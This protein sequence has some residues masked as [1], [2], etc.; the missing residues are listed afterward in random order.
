MMPMGCIAGDAMPGDAEA[1]GAAAEIAEQA[2]LCRGDL[3]LFFD[4]E[5]G[6]RQLTAAWVIQVTTRGD[7]VVETCLERCELLVSASQIARR[8]PS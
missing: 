7:V 8:I 6:F 3:V 4:A 1:A 2:G 5:R